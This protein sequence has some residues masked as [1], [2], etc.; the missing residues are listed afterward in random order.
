MARQKQNSNR[1]EKSFILR[2][3]QFLLIGI[4]VVFFLAFIITAFSNLFFPFQL[5]WLEGLMV[6]GVERVLAGK[7]LYPAPSLE[8]IPPIYPPFYFYLSAFISK[9]IGQGF[10]PLRLVSFLAS[11]G[12]F[13]FIFLLVKKETK[14]N[15]YSFLSSALFAA[16][17]FISYWFDLARVDS[18]FLFL[19]LAGVY[20]IRFPSSL[21]SYLLAGILISLSF[22]TKQTAFV[23]FLPLLLYSFLEN[24]KGSFL[25]IG[26]FIL[27]AG[28][29][30]L[31]FNYFHQGWYFFYVFDLPF[32]HPLEKNMFINFWVKDLFLFL[33][34]ASLLALFFLI[35]KSL[36]SDKKTFL[37]YFLLT[38][39]LI[40]S[41]L[42]GRLKVGGAINTLIPTYLIL[43]ISILFGLSLDKIFKSIK[44][45]PFYLPKFS[46]ILIY[47]FC[48]SQFVLLF[49]YSYHII[50][51][52]YSLRQKYLE[53]GE[54]LLKEISKIEGE[55]FLPAYGYLPRLV[56]KKTYLHAG[57]ILD[58]LNGKNEQ[59]KS[60]IINEMK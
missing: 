5:E 3:L 23:I 33:P 41:S 60:K 49:F 58:I 47:F 52:Y 7:K 59:I 56:Q 42:I 2:P 10:L 29:V 31:L 13:F 37:F 32:Q 22:L 35:S 20:L 8:F 38:I 40:F 51:S 15:F 57:S 28:P 44:M 16:T 26:T 1:L 9:I 18:L 4:A 45:T 14:N 12:S 27:V 19:L 30:S 48:L 54:I 34:I 39:G 53:S 36:K 43:I 24:K 21:N 17:Y 55:V 25:L 46:E 11:L 50:N 6:N